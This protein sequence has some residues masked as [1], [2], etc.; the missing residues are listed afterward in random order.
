MLL[1]LKMNDQSPV[2]FVVVYGYKEGSFILHDGY[3]KSVSI[4]EKDIIIMWKRGGNMAL[5]I[6]P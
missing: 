2:H 6:Y 3:R 5:W 1:A 4:P